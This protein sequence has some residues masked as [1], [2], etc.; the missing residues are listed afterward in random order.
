MPTLPPALTLAIPAEVLRQRPD[1]QAAER[2]LAAADARVEQIDAARLPS[3][4]LGGSIGLSALSLGALG[5]GA[6][7]ASLLASVSLPV[8]D[9]GR[10]QAQVRQ[11]EAARDEAAVA[12]R[13]TVLAALQEVE[14]TL[15]SLAGAREQLEARQAAADAAQ[16][17]ERLAGFRYASGLV[18][19]QAVLQTQRTLLGAEESVAAIATTLATAHVR[20]YKALGGG[21]NPD[22]EQAASR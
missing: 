9:A 11:Q 17:A 19:F 16:R 6:G 22:A 1:V 20:L 5:S 7:V 14:D 21:W 4:S 10:L 13:A 15:L 18:D 2:Q 3:L 8:L 12:Y